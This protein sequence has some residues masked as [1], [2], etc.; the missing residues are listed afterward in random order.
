MIVSVAASLLA[1]PAVAQTSAPAQPQTAAVDDKDKVV[2][3]REVETGSI[4]KRKKICHTK[5]EWEALAQRSREAFDQGQ[6]SGS[7]SGQ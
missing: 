4:A 5:R 2:C 3:R 7:T 1:V 6:M